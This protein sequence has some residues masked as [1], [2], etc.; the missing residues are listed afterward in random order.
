MQAGTVIIGSNA[1]RPARARTAQ[2]VSTRVRLPPQFSIGGALQRH[3]PGDRR[4]FVGARTDDR[5]RRDG[6]FQSHSKSDRHRRVYVNNTFN[7][8]NQTVANTSARIG[9]RM[10]GVYGGTANIN[11]DIVDASTA[12]TR[13]TTL[14]VD[15]GTLNISGQI[16][17]APRRRSRK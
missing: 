7:L 1:R 10:F 12:G 8:A 14:T 5:Q 4:F 3:R 9:Y 17:A 2:A 6:G 13:S 15:G 11:T 16:W